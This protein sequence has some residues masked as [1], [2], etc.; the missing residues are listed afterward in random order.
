[1]VQC[2]NVLIR[3]TYIRSYMQVTSIGMLLMI[4]MYVIDI[5]YIFNFYH[6]LGVQNS[7]P[8]IWDCL[9]HISIKNPLLD[10]LCM[11]QIISLPQ[12]NNKGEIGDDMEYEQRVKVLGSWHGEKTEFLAF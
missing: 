4:P 5:Y 10:P 3:H 1:M 2:M 11:G 9:L 6:N 12:Q 7:D 8:Y